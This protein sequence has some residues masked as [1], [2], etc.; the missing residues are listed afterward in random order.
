MKNSIQKIVKSTRWYRKTHRWIAIIS[1]FF[2]LIVSL[3]GLLITWKDELR[4]Q[5]PS[6]KVVTQNGTLLSIQTI[7]DNA[8]AHI[9]SLKLSPEINRIDYRPNKGMAKVRFE[10]HF[11]ELQI[12]CYTGAIISEKTRTA[13]IIEAIHDGSII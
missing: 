8:V 4:F 1:V 10:D 13:D 9:K 7:H 6:T 5:P 11:T 3:T 2:L 12:D